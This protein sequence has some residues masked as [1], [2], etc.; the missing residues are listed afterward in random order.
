VSS[1]YEGVTTIN[2][3]SDVIIVRS[4]NGTGVCVVDADD[5]IDLGAVAVSHN[6]DWPTNDVDCGN[7]V[8]T[9]GGGE[10]VVFI[11]DDTLVGN[12]SYG[13]FLLENSPRTLA[14]PGLQ[15]ESS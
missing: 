12:C 9:N 10:G 3:T 4:E 13:G 8:P 11:P 1:D 5:V 2:E 15:P 7:D 6:F 14:R